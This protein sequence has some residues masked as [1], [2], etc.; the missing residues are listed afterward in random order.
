MV[1]R[2]HIEIVDVEQDPDLGAGGLEDGREEGAFFHRRA[3]HH[4][5]VAHVLEEQ[6]PAEASRGAARVRPRDERRLVAEG[7]RQEIEERVSADRRVAEVVT[8]E[9][10]LE[11]VHQGRDHVEVAGGLMVA[12]GERDPVGDHR[13]SI[14]HA[15]EEVAR[16]SVQSGE[17]LAH[18]LDPVE[19]ARRRQQRL[20]DLA[21]QADSNARETPRD[22]L[23]CVKTKSLGAPMWHEAQMDLAEP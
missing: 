22:H 7:K 4:C 6:G 16:T 17:V 13:P 9:R 12:H 14:L 5:V 3:G 11:V 19:V 10:G 2:V 21:A 15:T 1:D 18:H 23:T 20:R 8:E